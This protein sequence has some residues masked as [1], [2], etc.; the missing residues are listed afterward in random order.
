MTLL[1][2]GIS[3]NLGVIGPTVEIIANEYA[4]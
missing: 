2:D 3:A 4:P 1:Q